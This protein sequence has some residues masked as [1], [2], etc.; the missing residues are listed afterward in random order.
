M[1]NVKPAFIKRIA[2]ELIQKFPEEFT[3]DFEKN[4]VLVEKLT[5]ISTKNV[6]NRIAGYIARIMEDSKKIENEEEN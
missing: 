2:L 3:D 1:G 4:K 5:T 6:R